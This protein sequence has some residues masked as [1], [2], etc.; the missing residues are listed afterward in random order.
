MRRIGKHWKVRECLD[1]RYS[2]DIESV[3]GVGF[4]GANTAF[5]EDDVVIAARKNVF[6]AKKKLFD[7]GG[8]AAFE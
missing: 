8:H 4:K 2:G 5:A 7:G 6:G 3:A 1:Y